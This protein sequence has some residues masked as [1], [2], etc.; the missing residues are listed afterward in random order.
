MRIVSGNGTQMKL[1]DTIGE[2]E[3]TVGTKL[4]PDNAAEVIALY[5][6]DI[7]ARDAEILRL[8]EHLRAVR[9]E[10]EQAWQR[11]QAALSP[12]KGGQK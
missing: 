1:R 10:I 6:R 11:V 12:L 4:H 3:A 8:Q 9:S 2:F 5:Q 7:A